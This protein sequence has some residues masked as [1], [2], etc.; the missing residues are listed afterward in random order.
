M[1]AGQLAVRGDQ[2]VPVLIPGERLGLALAPVGVQPVDQ[3]AALAG[4]VAGQPATETCGARADA[5]DRGDRA[6]QVLDRGG[7]ATGRTRP[8]DDPPARAAASFIW[9]RLGLPYLDGAVVAL[10][11]PARPIWHD[12]PR[13]RSRYQIGDGV[14]HREPAGPGRGSG[15][16]HAGH[17]S[18]RPA[19]AS[20][21]DSSRASCCSSS[22]HRAAALRCSGGRRP[23]TPAATAAPTARS[24]Q[25]SSNLAAG[26][27]CPNSPRPPAGPA[28][29]ACGLG[30]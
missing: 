7:S 1:T 15:Q 20:S 4:P 9:P 2:Q 17:R 13:R 22:R 29:G 27:R 16:R 6:R 12:Q 23:A 11:S 24:P 18:R 14:L 3:A 28:P 5:D 30:S 25:L 19:A 10:D 8:E 26:T 21:T